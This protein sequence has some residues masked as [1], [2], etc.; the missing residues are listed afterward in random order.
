[1]AN[2][3][4]S[5]DDLEIDEIVQEAARGLTDA[6]N[7]AYGTGLV[8]DIDIVERGVVGSRY[9]IKMLSVQLV[10]PIRAR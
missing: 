2:K 4:I 7:R 6:L 10:R 1:M 3:N 8:A 5:D 9:P